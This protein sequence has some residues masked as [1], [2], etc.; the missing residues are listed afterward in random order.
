MNIYATCLW[1][2]TESEKV[3]GHAISA[4]V[5]IQI[6]QSNMMAKLVA[7]TQVVV[8]L[9]Q[10]LQS[11][12]VHV[13]LD[14]VNRFIAMSTDEIAVKYMDVLRLEHEHLIDPPF[15]SM[16][17]RLWDYRRWPVSHFNNLLLTL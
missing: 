12:N 7:D 8:S 10:M 5:L 15:T 1:L 2:C 17:S 13:G 11:N 4:E 3:G 16:S 6:L 9:S 14:A